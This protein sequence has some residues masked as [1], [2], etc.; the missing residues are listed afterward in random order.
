V[1]LSATTTNALQTFNRRYQITLNTLMQ[2]CWA[3]LLAHGSNH[4]DVVFGATVSGRPTDLP[5]ADAMIGLFINTLPVR[6]QIPSNL[7]LLDWLQALQVQQVEARQYEYT[8][9]AQIQRWSQVPQGTPLF[10]TVLVFENYPVGADIQPDLQGVQIQAVQSAIRNHYPLTLRVAPHDE[11]SLLWM[12]DSNQLPTATVQHRSQ[13]FM[14]LLETIS[15]QPQT[16]IQ[17]LLQI[18]QDSDRQIQT[19]KAQTLDQVSRSSFQRTRRKA[20]QI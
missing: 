19:A 10:N 17:E 20:T 4:P 1:K 12:Y 7:L 16:S 13:Q 18:L 6:I 9:L 11:L 8:P 3:L 15:K 5:G 14:N 2:G